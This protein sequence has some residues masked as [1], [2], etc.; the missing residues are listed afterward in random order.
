MAYELCLV[1]C[2]VNIGVSVDSYGKFTQPLITL[3]SCRSKFRRLDFH[4]FYVIALVKGEELA[5]VATIR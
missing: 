2:L 1:V 4:G 5:C 3:L